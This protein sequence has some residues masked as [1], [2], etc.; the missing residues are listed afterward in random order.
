VFVGWGS[1]SYFS[2]YAPSGRQIF[3][4]WMHSPIQSYRA[5]RFHWVGK[6]LWPPAI[7]IRTSSA[8]RDR[9]YMSWNGATRVVKWRIEAGAAGQGSFTTIKTVPWQSFET[10]TQVL[11]TK[12]PYFRVQALSANGRLLPH[13][14]S[15]A[16]QAPSKG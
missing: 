8:A 16:V 2:E 13:G 7:A 12:G 11:A 1:R 5:Y 4:A 9:I 6:P 14:T 3:S 10:S 15:P